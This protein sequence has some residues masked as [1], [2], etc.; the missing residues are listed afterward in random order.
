MRI[1]YDLVLA[2]LGDPV[3]TA[4]PL[5]VDIESRCMCGETSLARRSQTAKS[6]AEGVCSNLEK[7]WLS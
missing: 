2:G 7:F 4:T 6:L 5:I 1:E 3:K